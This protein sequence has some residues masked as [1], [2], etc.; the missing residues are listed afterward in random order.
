MTKKEERKKF[1]EIRKNIKNKEELSKK[2]AENL[3]ASEIYKGAKSVFAFISF[4]TEVDTKEI[5]GKILEDKKI[6]LVPKVVGEEMILIKTLSFDNLE[7]STLG[8]LEPTSNEAYNGEISLTL[9]PG[10]AF[11]ADG[12][13]LGYGGGYY[14]RFF[15]KTKTIK[16]GL[17][18][19]DQ[20]TENLYHEE[21]DQKLDYVITEKRIIKF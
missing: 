20:L 11:S 13:R 12:Y 8:I 1:K 6:L 14:D 19:N 16:A 21:F 17:A 5:I 9:T 10:L 18:F 15:A 7:K 2:I 4:R 3:F